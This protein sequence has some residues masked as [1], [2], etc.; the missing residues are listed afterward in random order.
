MGLIDDRVWG[1]PVPDVYELRDRCREVGAAFFLKQGHGFAP[2]KDLGDVPAD[3][4]VRE[5][6][7][8]VS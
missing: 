3:L 5:M 2:R 7:E 1:W 8:V 4:R 6:P